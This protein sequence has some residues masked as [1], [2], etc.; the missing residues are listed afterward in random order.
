[1]ESGGGEGRCSGEAKVTEGES[2]VVLIGRIERGRVI[3]VK[4]GKIAMEETARPNK[5]EGSVGARPA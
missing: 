3:G 2:K 1:M 4:D 5:M